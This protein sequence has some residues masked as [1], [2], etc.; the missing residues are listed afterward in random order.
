MKAS[1]PVSALSINAASLGHPGA[2][3]V[4]D[5][6]VEDNIEETVTY[7]WL[8]LAHHKHMKSTNMVRAPLAAVGT[9]MPFTSRRFRFR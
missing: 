4:G 7:Y 3:L 6:W 9:N 2:E 8:P 1:T 5:A